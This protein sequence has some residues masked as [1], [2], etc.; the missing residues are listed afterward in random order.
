MTDKLF[1]VVRDHCKFEHCTGKKDLSV[2]KEQCADTQHLVNQLIE[3]GVVIL[4]VKPGD[5]VY[6]INH[7]R[8]KEC[9]VCF[10]GINKLGEIT[11]NVAD[12]GYDN[13]YKFWDDTIGVS[14]FLTEEDAITE[15][16]ER[17]SYDHT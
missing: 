5:P 4:P 15:L 3:R 14:V 12:D 6:V 9:T 2:C 17:Q 13:V 8:I 10:V 7:N 11:F 1:A 16:K